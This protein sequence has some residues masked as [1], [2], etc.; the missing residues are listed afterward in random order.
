ML[1]IMIENSGSL[2]REQLQQIQTR[3]EHPEEAAETTALIN[4]HKRLR[5]R[6]GPEAG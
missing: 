4:I 5:L 6:Y 3:L 2:T 1:D